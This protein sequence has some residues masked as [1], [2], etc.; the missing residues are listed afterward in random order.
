[1]LNR[2][3]EIAEENRYISLDRG[4]IVIESKG[5]ELGRIPLDD[6]AVLLLSAQTTTLTKN[7]INA[8]AERGCIS[9]F[10]GKNYIPQSITIP[11][12]LHSL[13]SK[14]LRMQISA[15][16]PFKKK[17][18]QQIVIRKIEH[19]AMVLDLFGKNS[20]LVMKISKM[21]KSGDTENRE[22]YAARIYWTELFGNSFIRDKNGNGINAMLNYGYAIMRAAMIR[23]ICVH[24]L[25][26]SLGIFHDN[27]LNSFCLSDDFFEVY[28]PIVDVIVYKEVQNGEYELTPSVKKNLA[29]ILNIIVDIRN[30]KT[31]IVQSM[32]IM[33]SSY[34]NAL[35]KKETLMTLPELE[36]N[37]DGIAIIESV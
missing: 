20:A 2:V 9:V 1:M 28:R 4:F 35:E 22:A 30:E 23:A 13:H 21:V 12:G 16:E 26:P 14:I 24:G 10:C 7:I 11:V 36:K 15:S 19:Q 8:L 17:V 33:V 27:K 37:A 5:E 25:E 32:N 34:V 3:L 6:I 29:K 18:W 31:Q